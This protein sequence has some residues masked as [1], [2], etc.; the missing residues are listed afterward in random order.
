MPS[1][2][3]ARI[4]TKRSQSSRS[5]S[6]FGSQLAQE[7]LLQLRDLLHFHAHDHGLAG[8]DRA[9]NQQHVVEIIIA[10]RSD[11]GTLVDF[12]GIEKIQNR[13]AL[14]VQHLVHAFDAQTPLAVEKVGDVRLLESGF[15]SQAK[16]G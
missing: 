6:D 1:R 2:P 14:D 4:I 11:A 12:A 5:P 8:S 7:A 15:V 16:A 13:K 10:G 9:V 3:S